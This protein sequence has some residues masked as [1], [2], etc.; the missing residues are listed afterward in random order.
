MALDPSIILQSG[1]PTVQLESP[2]NALLNASQLQASQ[3]QNALFAANAADKQ[4]ALADQE[5]VRSLLRGG[6]DGDALIRAG[7]VEPGT[8]LNK[9]RN[10]DLESKA[11]S[12]KDNADTFAKNIGIT[13]NAINTISPDGSNLGAVK[14]WIASNI[15]K[16]YADPIPDQWDPATTPQLIASL[17]SHAIDRK[18]EIEQQ[19]AAATAA[20]IARHNQSG[21]ALT[22]R[23]QNMTAATAAAG[24]ALEERGLQT[25]PGA[26]GGFY[27]APRFAPAG[28]AAGSDIQVGQMV[29]KDGKPVTGATKGQNPTESQSNAALYAARMQDAERVLEAQQGNYNRTGLAVSQAVQNVPG[30]GAVANAMTPAAAQQVDQA[31]RNFVNATLRRESGAAISN[32]EFQSAKKQYFPQPGDSPEVI[33]Q[34]AQNR[35]TAIQGIS[36]ASGPAGVQMDRARAA[37]RVQLP[38]PP[39]QKGQPASVD[40]LLKKY[41]GQ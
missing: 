27:T 4:R 20:E 40:D 39:S 29:G 28:Q 26:D 8:K 18:T 24:R 19:Q 11:K 12:G 5:Q 34:K 23:G 30:V 16:Q 14:S 3:N 2:I 35:A 10:D 22:A 21:E 9:A 38:T 13:Y 36:V 37:E 41:G 6:A 25:V 33:A 31:Q 17:K 15:G 7:Y 1:R 32:G